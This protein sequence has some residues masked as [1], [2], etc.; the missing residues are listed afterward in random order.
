[1]GKLSVLLQWP[2]RT[3]PHILSVCPASVVQQTA[4]MRT[5]FQRHLPLPCLTTDSPLNCLGDAPHSACLSD[6]GS[7]TGAFTVIRS[8]QPQ[9]ITS[10]PYRC[11]CTHTCIVTVILTMGSVALSPLLLYSDY[12]YCHH[13]QLSYLLRVRCIVAASLVLTH[14]F[15]YYLYCHHTLYNCHTY[16]GV[17][18]IVT[19]SLVH[20]VTWWT[21]PT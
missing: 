10:S 12:L 4:P 1:M 17:R 18:C 11:I 19:A 15:C 6:F 20:S 9:V 8:D 3:V 16:E 21:A 5:P 13:T 7:S 14:T 2:Q